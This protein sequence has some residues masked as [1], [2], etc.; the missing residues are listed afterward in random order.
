LVLPRGI[1][2]TIAERLRQRRRHI[3]AAPPPTANAPLA[4]PIGAGG[5]TA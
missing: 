3:D 5:I 2:P 4:A 1:L